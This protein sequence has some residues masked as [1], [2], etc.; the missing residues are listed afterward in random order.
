MTKPL[1][2]LIAIATMALAGTASAALVP[3][4]YDP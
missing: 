2:L 1:L 3:A 4:A